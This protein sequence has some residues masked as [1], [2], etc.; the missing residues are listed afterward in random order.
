ML[1]PKIPGDGA[2]VG[3]GGAVHLDAQLPLGRIPVQQLQPV[4][5]DGPRRQIHGFAAPGSGMGPFAIHMDGGDLRWALCNRRP[6]TDRGP[7]SSSSGLHEWTGQ[8]CCSSSSPSRSSLLVRLPSWMTP[9]I[10]LLPGEVGQ[11]SGG[12]AQGDG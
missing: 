5:R 2:D 4:H 12:R 8:A 1:V 10:G 11:Q 9:G 7:L 6:G 3:A